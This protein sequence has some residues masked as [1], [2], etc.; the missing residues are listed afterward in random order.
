[1]AIS[2]AFPADRV[3]RGLAIKQYHEQIGGAPT[4]FRPARVAVVG[5]GALA[6]TY[7]TTK[8]QVFSA[9]EAGTIYGYD[10]EIYGAVL[11]LLPQ[12]GDGVGAIPVTVYPLAQPTGN[13]AAGSITPTGTGTKAETYYVTVG[14]I[15]SQAIITS[16]GTTVAQWCTAA[17]AAINAIIGM[18][19]AAVDGTTKVDFT[20]GWKGATGNDIEIAVISPDDPEFTFALVQPTGG[21]GTITMAAATAQVGNVWETHIVNCAGPDTTILTEWQ[22][23]GDG[24]RL[25]AVHKAVTVYSGVNTAAVG[26][27][28]ALTNAR[29]TDAINVFCTNPASGD[30]PWVIAARYVARIAKLGNENPAHDYGRQQLTGLTAGA[31]GSQWTSA[32]RDTAV[33]A[34]CSTVEVIDGVVNISDVVTCYHPTGEEPPAFRYVC[35]IQKI[36]TVVYNMDL[37]FGSTEWAG[38]PLVPDNQTVKNPTAKKPKM[39]RS[40]M[41]KMFNDLAAE[42]VISD[43]DFAIA[44]STADISST[45]SKR[46]DIKAVFKLSGN[47]N[48]IS[49]DVAFGFYY[50]EG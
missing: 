47:S 18:P 1:M 38:A 13:A 28:A 35:D 17:T 45:N 33:K 37:I 26:T 34:G 19:G 27:V 46:L 6:T 49:T 2:T 21:S 11:A 42:A 7:S 12:N 44:N 8:R 3:A 4:R 14:N 15:R 48:V 50:G 39:A 29:K 24:R 41:A 23:F 16:V 32:Q 40:A 10:S 9:N 25:P 22:T 43:P 36:D 30:M 20:V 31:D 5:L